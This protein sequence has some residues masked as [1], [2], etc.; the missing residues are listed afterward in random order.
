MIKPHKHKHKN[1]SKPCIFLILMLMS[2]MLSA[3]CMHRQ[4][5]PAIR[6]QA[7]C[8]VGHLSLIQLSSVTYEALV[9]STLFIVSCF[10]VTLYRL[11]GALTITCNHLG[12]K[13]I[14]SH[15][16]LTW[17]RVNAHAYPLGDL[18]PRWMLATVRARSQIEQL[19]PEPLVTEIKHRVYGKRQT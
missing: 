12:F 7:V 4:R 5:G 1:I 8:D 16:S 17:G 19:C 14:K 15:P 9:K 3:C 13:C 11:D 10:S 6:L 18:K 2:L